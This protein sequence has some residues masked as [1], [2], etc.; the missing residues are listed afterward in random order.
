MTRWKSSLVFSA[1]VISLVSGS[2]LAQ[3]I[4]TVEFKP[5]KPL[6]LRDLPRQKR[7][8]HGECCA[9]VGGACISICNQGYCTGVGDCVLVP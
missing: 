5:K 6:T 1:F 4:Q 7:I 2:V 8:G 9:H 3:D